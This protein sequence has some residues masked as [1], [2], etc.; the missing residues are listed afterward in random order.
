[1][2]V[3]KLFMANP[4]TVYS[5]AERFHRI[6]NR[7]KQIDYELLKKMKNAPETLALIIRKSLIETGLEKKEQKN[8]QMK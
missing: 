8:L 3:I 2:Q 4:R 6:K 1:M 7:A 5:I